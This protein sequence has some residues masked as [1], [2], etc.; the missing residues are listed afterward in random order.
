MQYYRE[1]LLDGFDQL[2]GIVLS[3]GTAKGVSRLAGDVGESSHGRI[4][5]IGYLPATLAGRRNAEPDHRF[6]EIRYTT[7]SDFSPLEPLQAWMD[8]LAS[9]ASPS[10]VKL[11]GI[12]GGNVS[13]FEYRLA[14]A[15][16]ATVGIVRDSGREA[17]ALLHD[18]DWIT[19][20]NLVALP[21][22]REA[23]RMFLQSDSER[24]QRG[25]PTTN[26][27]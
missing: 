18:R 26:A 16:K 12:N 7:G 22:D 23:I 6:G 5:T 13:A 24:L 20:P 15:V 25:M 17:D 21:A 2:E 10:K 3:G 9:G 11:I 19:V 27:G 14:L 8:L 4:A 1:V